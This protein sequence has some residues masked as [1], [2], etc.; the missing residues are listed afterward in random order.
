MK[1]GAI[2]DTHD[3]LVAVAAAVRFFED[4]GVETILH[5]GDYC[6]PFA[7]KRLLQTRIPVQGV[8]GNCD[9][10]R[11]GLTQLLPSL[12]RGPRHLEL[13]GK[14]I[15]LIHDRA[16]LA[17]EDFE[18][19]DILVFGHTHQAE[20]RREEGRLVVNPGECAGWLTGRCTVAVIDTD[21][22]SADIEVIHEQP[23]A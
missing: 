22:L 5:A 10:E 1:I 19:S 18:A 13:G 8:F 3:N 12:T 20:V 14:K 9:G 16:R 4:Q 6:A 7:L 2:S 23:R 17:H 11:E 21:T 15:C